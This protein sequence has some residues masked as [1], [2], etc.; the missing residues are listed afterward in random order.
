MALLL[1]R[2]IVSQ[3]LMRKGGQAEAGVGYTDALAFVRQDFSGNV[4]K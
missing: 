4:D 3:T 2:D 1:P